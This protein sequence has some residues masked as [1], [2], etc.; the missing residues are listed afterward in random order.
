M[1]K[2]LLNFKNILFLIAIMC[3]AFG[4]SLLIHKLFDTV[5]LIP[6]IFVLAVFI[7][8]LVTEGYGYGIA[9]SVVSVLA[10][11]YAFTFPYFRFNFTMSENIV[12]A[13][14]M[15]IVTLITGT[16]TTKL[17]RQEAIKAES[18]KERMRANLLRAVSHDLRTPL[19][20]IYGSSSTILDNYEGLSD[21]RKKQ[22]LSGIKEESEWLTRMVENL[23]S[24]TRLD[25]EN[26]RLIKS[27]TVLDELID[28]VLVKFRKKYPDTSVL[29]SLPEEFTV[30]PMDAMLIEQV[31]LN[32]LSNAV[33]HAKGMTHIGLRVYRE[34]KMAVF[35]ISDDGC[36]IAPERL[37][38]IFS[39]CYAE[40]SAP[41]DTKINSGI[42]LSVCFSIIK[43]HGSRIVAEN[44]EEGGAT[45][46]F[47]LETEDDENE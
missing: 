21:K 30:I 44:N 4:I 15:I 47:S 25:S 41:S 18:E 40:S 33:S 29:L 6:A 42:G 3:A 24:V 43:A 45:F 26:V 16:L 34:D 9:A 17:K 27:P 38:N 46:R 32:I 39:G 37:G 11:N 8:S 7:I 13:V 23:L 1:K 28:S 31:L 14:I 20:T 10:V 22:M 19:T 35:E 36:G 5:A 12:S 2:F